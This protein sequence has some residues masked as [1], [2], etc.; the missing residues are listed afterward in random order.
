MK[1]LTLDDLLRGNASLAPT[2]VDVLASEGY[3][4]LLQRV[5]HLCISDFSDAPHEEII[6]DQL[7]DALWTRRHAAHAATEAI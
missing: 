3:C 2:T 4:A 5:E 1:T 7:Y 6:A